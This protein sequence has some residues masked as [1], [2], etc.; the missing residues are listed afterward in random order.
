MECRVMDDGNDEL[1]HLF[2]RSR[3]GAAVLIRARFVHKVTNFKTSYL[4]SFSH[5]VPKQWARG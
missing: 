4:L 2:G 5:E 3:G 1:G